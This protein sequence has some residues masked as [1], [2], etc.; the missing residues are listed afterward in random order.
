MTREEAIEDLLE[1]LSD[2]KK[3]KR[4]AMTLAETAMAE[5]DIPLTEEDD[6][7]EHVENCFMDCLTKEMR[8]METSDALDAIDSIEIKN[9]VRQALEDL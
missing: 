4:N 1:A 6:A 7:T 9:E 5:R 8:V 2:W 3:A